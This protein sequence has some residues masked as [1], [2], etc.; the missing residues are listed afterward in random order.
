MEVHGSTGEPWHLTLVETGED[1]PTG[2][3]LRKVAELRKGA[4]EDLVKSAW[5]GRKVFLTG[6]TGFKGGWLALRLAHLGANVRGYALAPAT[7][8]SFFSTARV[9]RVIDDIRG[10]L[11]EPSALDRAMREFQPEAVFHLAAQALVRPS[12]ADPVGTYSTNVMGTAHVL[13]SIRKLPSV[14]AAVI[15][16]TDKCYLNREWHWGYRETDPLG[17]ND[18][19]SSSK[20]CVEIL[21]ASY[22]NSY[23]PPERFATHGVALATAR[24]ANVIGGGDWSEDRLLP[25]LIRGFLSGKPVLIRR[26][27][28][29]RS[30]QHVLEPVAGYLALGERLLAGE[31]EFAEAWNFGP[32]DDDAWPVGQI[33]TEMA[34]RWGNGASWIA[35]E[36]ESVHEAGYLKVDSSK[37]RSRL[38]WRPRLKLQS[39]LEWLVDWYQAWHHGANMHEFSLSQIARYETLMRASGGDSPAIEPAPANPDTEK[40]LKESV[41]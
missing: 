19:Y 9:D 39:A 18:P 23:F 6:H 13:E 4:M 32:W 10:D 40:T 29:I 5:Q 26:A 28:A 36:S 41:C 14:R 1:T 22:R 30:W 11:R 12:Y 38:H 34:H 21:S 33:A 3:R 7:E 16:T 15:V 35:D 24:A 37:A 8:P 17:G 31:M 25:D 2:G 20:A 27:H